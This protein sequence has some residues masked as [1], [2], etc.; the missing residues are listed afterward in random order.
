[1]SYNYYFYIF[2]ATHFKLVGVRTFCRQVANHNN[3]SFLLPEPLAKCTKS[4]YVPYIKSLFTYYSS[5]HISTLRKLLFIF[6]HSWYNNIN[7]L[8]RKKMSLWYRYSYF[9]LI[10]TIT[11]IKF[12]FN[13][14][15]YHDFE[16][17]NHALNASHNFYV[18]E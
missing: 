10:Y 16:I 14:V 2:V 4:C 12:Y 6:Y 1:M 18:W 11:P 3:H 5:K 7:V 13:Q 9:S 15:S 8:W 17:T